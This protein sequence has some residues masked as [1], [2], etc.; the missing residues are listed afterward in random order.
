MNILYRGVY[1]EVLSLVKVF[2]KHS[3]G[4]Y[5]DVLFLVKVFLILPIDLEIVVLGTLPRDRNF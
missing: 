2:L 4:V 1:Q 5:Q 3:L